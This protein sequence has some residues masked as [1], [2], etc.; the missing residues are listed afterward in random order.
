MGVGYVCGGKKY[1]V[2][3]GQEVIVCAGSIQ[4]PQILELSGVGSKDLLEKHQIRMAVDL[5]A[6]GENLRDH[7]IAPFSWVSRDGLFTVVRL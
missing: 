1:M 3:I 4:S 7:I 6:V 5:P 2:Q